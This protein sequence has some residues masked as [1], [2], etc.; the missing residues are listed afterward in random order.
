ME[1][2]EPETEDLCECPIPWERNRRGG[3]GSG[4]DSDEMSL[5]V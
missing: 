4:A 1:V 2:A 5:R 3:T